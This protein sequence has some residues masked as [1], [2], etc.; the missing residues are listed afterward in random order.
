MLNDIITESTAMTDNFN[1][2]FNEFQNFTRQQKIINVFRLR[3][4]KPF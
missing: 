1:L 3:I 4:N 2:I